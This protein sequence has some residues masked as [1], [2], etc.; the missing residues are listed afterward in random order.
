MTPERR[1]TGQ[2]DRVLASLGRDEQREH[3]DQPLRHP[4]LRAVPQGDP[5]IGALAQ[6]IRELGEM[7]QVADAHPIYSERLAELER[8]AGVVGIR[9][10]TLRGLIDAEYMDACGAGA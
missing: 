2:R 9:L 3:H 5:T 7:M 1:P 6:S 4:L 10:A 8:L